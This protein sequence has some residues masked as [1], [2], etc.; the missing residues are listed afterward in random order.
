MVYGGSSVRF[1]NDLEKRLWA[2]L[3]AADPD[4][5][6]PALKNDCPSKGPP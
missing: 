4:P 3:D 2:S 5:D 1:F 6:A